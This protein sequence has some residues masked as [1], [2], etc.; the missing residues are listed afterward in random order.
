MAAGG[1]AVGAVASVLPGSGATSGRA[2]SL[3]PDGL[4]AE[5]SFT[6]GPRVGEAGGKEG[7]G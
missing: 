6:D 4:A 5:E 3:A 1:T 2:Q 7:P